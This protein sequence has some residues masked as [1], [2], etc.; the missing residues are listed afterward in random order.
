[1]SVYNACSTGTLGEPW[2]AWQV[3]HPKPS[4]SLCNACKKPLGPQWFRLLPKC[5]GSVQWEMREKKA[6]RA[7]GERMLSASAP[8]FGSLSRQPVSTGL[9]PST[10]RA[11]WS[12][13]GQPHTHV[14]GRRAERVVSAELGPL[15]GGARIQLPHWVLLATRPAAQS[16]VRAAA[17][18]S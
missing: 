8:L 18:C 7:H 14:W 12:G 17:A 6:L 11:W 13:R 1:M 10:R 9:L 16:G 2:P 3:S 5:F 4:S 15:W